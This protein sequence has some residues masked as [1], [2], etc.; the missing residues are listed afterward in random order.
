M[1]VELSDRL[2]RLIDYGNLTVADLAR[3]LERPHPTGRGWVMGGRLG[4]PAL[5]TAFVLAR[6]K[7]LEDRLRKKRGLPVPRMSARK[8]IVYME[9]L[10]AQ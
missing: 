7:L 1:S 10:R 2:G 3:W 9:G 6:V 8:R 5:D 4:G